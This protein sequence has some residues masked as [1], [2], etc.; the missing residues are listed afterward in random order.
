LRIAAIRELFEETSI[1]LT[2]PKVYD[3]SRTAWRI[4]VQKD[5]RKFYEM[6]KEYKCVPKVTS[7][8]N[9][10]HWIT[11]RQEKWRYDTYFFLAIDY[12]VDLQS[13]EH[14]NNETTE[15]SWFYPQEALQKL[16]TKAISVLPPTWW[17]LNEL[18]KFHSVGMLEQYARQGRDMTPVQPTLIIGDEPSQFAV[19]LPGDELH[20]TSPGGLG[21]R[22]R[23]I[24][25]EGNYQ[26]ECNLNK[27]IKSSL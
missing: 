21:S 4:K 24:L 12:D 19:I 13:S 16:E 20:E 25:H 10:A 17:M 5:P 11:P 22:N 14:D 6:I 3:S 27:M 15:V 23:V 8:C 2:E 7:L 26:Y 1:L 18:S 9:W